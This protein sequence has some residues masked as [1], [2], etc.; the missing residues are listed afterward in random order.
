MTF[1]IITD[2]DRFTMD[3]EGLDELFALGA[4]QF[5]GQLM[6]IDWDE[7]TITFTPQA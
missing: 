5:K 3:I 7:L 4:D 1:T 6:T 2:Q